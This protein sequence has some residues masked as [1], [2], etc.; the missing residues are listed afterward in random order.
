MNSKNSVWSFAAVAG[1]LV[2][3]LA[4]SAGV[5]AATPTSAVPVKSATFQISL[6]FNPPD[7]GAPG[8]TTG[9]GSRALSACTRGR[10]PLTL[11]VPTDK[12]GKF[13]LTAVP[14]PTLLVYVPKTNAR[15]A[16]VTLV[17]RN[18]QNSKE[19][20]GL[21]QATIPLSGEAGIITVKLPDSL[22][23]LEVGKDYQW[24]F[25]LICN[26][27]ERTD[28]IVSSAWISRT[29]PK[30]A[31]AKALERAKPHDRPALYSSSSYWYDTLAALSELR[32]ANPQDLNLKADWTQLLKSVGLKEVAEQPLLRPVSAP[33]PTASG[34][35]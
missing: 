22:P 5:L 27:A 3:G 20:D 2:T 9:G 16:E 23:D 19:S 10:M 7:R 32:Q 25:S 33:S 35:R 17:G 8:T 31:L 1:V 29:P 13:G 6:N 15:S 4:G 24:Y 11:L 21:G 34:S 18:S 14:R 26:P 12:V 28:D 30:P